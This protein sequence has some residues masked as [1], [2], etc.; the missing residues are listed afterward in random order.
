MNS[1]IKDT[2]EQVNKLEDK[3]E[4]AEEKNMIDI[5]DI[6]KTK[7]TDWLMKHKWEIGGGLVILIEAGKYIINFINTIPVK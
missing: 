7:A 3:F 6:E 1:D 2:K 4:K 5:R